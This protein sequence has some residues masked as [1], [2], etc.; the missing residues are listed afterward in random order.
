MFVINLVLTLLGYY[1]FL[2]YT[3]KHFPKT[4]TLC[5]NPNHVSINDC[6]KDLFARKY[7]DHQCKIAN[8]MYHTIQIRKNKNR[9]YHYQQC[10]RV[11]DYL[12]KN[13]IEFPLECRHVGSLLT[14]IYQSSSKEGERI[15]AQAINMFIQT[16]KMHII[17]KNSENKE[18]SK[19]FFKKDDMYIF[20]SYSNEG[21]DLFRNVFIRDTSG[22]KDYPNVLFLYKRAIRLLLQEPRSITYNVYHHT[23]IN[24]K[25]AIDDFLNSTLK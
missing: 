5:N 9:S 2:L 10:L 1:T 18:Q 24:E 16:E 7:G 11:L 4:F 17:S 25:N 15:W 6:Q 19:Y 3:R 20:N 14:N 22:L 23:N 21:G 13:N 12:R 8:L